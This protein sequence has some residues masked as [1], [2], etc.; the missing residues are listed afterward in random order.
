MLREVFIQDGVQKLN[1]YCFSECSS[2]RQIIMPHSTVYFGNYCFND[3]YLLEDIKISAETNFIGNAIFRNCEALKTINSINNG[4]FIL[5]EKIKS[6]GD[7]A[8][9]NCTSL[10]KIFYGDINYIGDYAF[11]NCINLVQMNSH[12]LYDFIFPITIMTMGMGCIQNIGKITNLTIPFVGRSNSST[13]NASSVFGYIFNYSGIENADCVAQRYS[14][15]GNNSSDIRYSTIY[16]YI[17]RTIESV[18]ILDASKIQ[19]G[20]FDNCS[21]IK[22]IEVYSTSSSFTIGTFSFANC[23]SLTNIVLPE[24]AYTIKES[25]FVDCSSLKELVL[26][27]ITNRIYAYALSGCNALEELTVS[28]TSVYSSSIDQYLPL[29]AIFGWAWRNPVYSD[30]LNMTVDDCQEL[31]NDLTVIQIKYVGYNNSVKKYEYIIF[32]AYVPQSLKV[33]NLSNYVSTGTTLFNLNMLEKINFLDDCRIFLPAFNWELDYI[34]C[35]GHVVIEQNW[36]KEN[37][38]LVNNDEI[39]INS[40]GENI[41]YYRQTNQSNIPNESITIIDKFGQCYFE[42]CILVGQHFYAKSSQ[43]NAVFFSDSIENIFLNDSISLSD[44]NFRLAYRSDNSYSQVVFPIEYTVLTDFDTSSAGEKSAVI[45]YNDI[46]YTLTYYVYSLDDITGVSEK[47][48]EVGE[49]LT[50]KAHF[51][52]FRTNSNILINAYIPQDSFLEIIDTSTATGGNSR[53]ARF[54]YQGRT[55]NLEYIVS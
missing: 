16:C 49:D 39:I 47:Y 25:A 5:P 52:C 43:G 17:Q 2:L 31:G 10:V 11:K 22:N 42:K 33:L 26:P 1:D 23:S 44:L 27:K 13:Y 12:S 29:G 40:Y 3:C 34:R 7:N 20:A 19:D 38:I 21:F 54:I 30:K 28:T 45:L 6:I 41:I 35:Y 36:D 46:E 50:I 4:C 14:Y 37:K 15:I 24:Y 9:E 8:F 55:Y 48:F 18:Y 32:Y 51:V 53:I